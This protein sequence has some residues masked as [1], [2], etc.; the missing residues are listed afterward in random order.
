MPKK[1]TIVLAYRVE[2]EF[3]LKNILPL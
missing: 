1:Y 3:V 2:K